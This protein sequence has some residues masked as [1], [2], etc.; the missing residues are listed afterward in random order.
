MK[1][2]GLRCG[3]GH[4]WAPIGGRDGGCLSSYR[5]GGFEQVDFFSGFEIHMFPI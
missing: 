4:C 5:A 3:R 2:R 1:S